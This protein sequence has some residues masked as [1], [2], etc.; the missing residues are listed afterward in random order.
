MGSLSGDT[1]IG[2]IIEHAPI[3]SGGYPPKGFAMCAGQKLPIK[4]NQALF[5]ILGFN[6]G[7]DP[8]QQ[9]FSL[10]DLRGKHPLDPPDGSSTVYCIALYGIFPSRA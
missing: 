5:S 10:P 9:Y 2:Q 7:Y 1:Y 6:Y 3:A 8:Q 4:S